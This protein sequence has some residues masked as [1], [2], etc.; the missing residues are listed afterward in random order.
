LKGAYT[1]APAGLLLLIA[2]AIISTGLGVAWSWRSSP[3]HAS[4]TPNVCHVVVGVV[5]VCAGLVKFP[6]EFV[7]FPLE[8]VVFPLEG[9][10][11]PVAACS[12]L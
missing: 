6:L 3:C 5:E 7:V 1:I 11:F 9:V 4:K 8:F 12:F 2:R 10:V